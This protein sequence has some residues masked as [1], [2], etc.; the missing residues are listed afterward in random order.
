MSTPY[1]T[2]LMLNS[3][4]TGVSWEILPWPQ[5]TT[6][7]Q[8]EEQYNICVRATKMVDGYTNQ[9]FRS[10]IDSEEQQG[11]NYWITIDNNTGQLRWIL[12]RWPVTEI[13][14][15][16]VASN[17]LPPQWQPV[18]AG[19]WRIATP[20]LGTYG[21]YLSGGSGGSG[22][23]TIY[24]A[25]GYGGWANGRN[26]YLAA[27]SYM[28]GW[29]HA[30]IVESVDAGAET[31]MVDNVT[32]FAGATAYIYDGASSEE[33]SVSSVTATSNVVLPNSGGTAPGG[34]GTVTLASPLAFAHTGGAPPGVVISSI[35]ADVLWAT[36]LAATT[37]ALESG[38]NAITIQNVSGS[39]TVGGHGVEQLDVEWK[40]L[41]NP[42][43]RVI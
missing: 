35:P 40:S 13:L 29:P 14:A 15:A 43:K 21:S 8:Y 34:P 42:Y 17:V 12:T 36:M 26:G 41:L 19:S 16:Q 4:P 24:L 30:G 28:N 27:C 9:V 22:G 3:A 32:G 2:P 20:M 31:I 10:T 23:Q 5:A 39:Q 37:Q 11:P 25:A 7:E 18:M 1:I 33:V 38:I 6:Q